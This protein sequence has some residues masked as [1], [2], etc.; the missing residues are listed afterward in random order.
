MDFSQGSG[1]GYFEYRPIDVQRASSSS[2]WSEDEPVLFECR[3]S[4]VAPL[5]DAKRRAATFVEHCLDWLSLLHGVAAGT[6]RWEYL[7]DE[8]ELNACRT[9]DG[10]TFTVLP[11]GKP[12][13]TTSGARN[14]LIATTL[15][16]EEIARCARWLRKAM[17]STNIEDR[18]LLL[19]ATCE[20]LSRKIKVGDKRQVTCPQCQ[21]SYEIDPGVDHAGFKQILDELFADDA[22]KV[23]RTLNRLRGSIA[24]GGKHPKEL[25][26]DLLQYE[27][28]IK[29][30]AL[31]SLAHVMGV[32][33]ESLDLLNFGHFEI[34]PICMAKLEDNDPSDAWGCSITE[35]LQRSRGK[36]QR[37]NDS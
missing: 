27:S 8:T 12:T 11:I 15:F 32:P 9:S 30:T 34:M 21:D 13:F 2:W 4:I 7:Y 18:F 16:D 35:R 33:R 3:A 10:T 36:D 6:P 14:H 5:S 24:H 29:A 26:S 22:K 31:A 19:F 23:Y 25:F 17:L 1:D 20:T 28:I 37:C